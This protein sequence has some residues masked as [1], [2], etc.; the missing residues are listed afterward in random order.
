[1]PERVS[2]IARDAELMFEQVDPALAHYSFK[3]DAYVRR[4]CRLML[5]MLNE[6]L[7]PKPILI[8]PKFVAGKTVHPLGA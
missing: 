2:L 5:Q 6:R 4:L 3:S 7:S 8:V 1:V